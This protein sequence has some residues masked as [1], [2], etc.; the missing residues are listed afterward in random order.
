MLTRR[1]TALVEAFI[2]EPDDTLSDPPS[3]AEFEV[4]EEHVNQQLA[5]EQLLSE[6]AAARDVQMVTAADSTPRKTPR[7]CNIENELRLTPGQSN[8]L[9]VLMNEE[10]KKADILGK[11]NFYPKSKAQ[12]E[13]ALSHVIEAAKRELDFLGEKGVDEDR[14]NELLMARA[15]ICN[16]NEKHNEFM[17]KT[18]RVKARIS[19]VDPATASSAVSNIQQ[20]HIQQELASLDDD[21]PIAT[22]TRARSEARTERA[23]T[24]TPIRRRTR[25]STAI[26]ARL[27]DMDI[28]TAAQQ[29]AAEEE[30]VPAPADNDTEQQPPAI[31][32]QFNTGIFTLYPTA[33]LIRVIN[34]TTGAAIHAS[35][36][37]PASPTSIDDMSYQ[38]FIDKVTQAVGF[39]VRN[40]ISAVVP[41]ALGSAFVSNDVRITIT[42]E[43][44]WRA[45]LQLW[46]NARKRSCEFVVGGKGAVEG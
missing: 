15:H 3:D 24:P 45:A 7:V 14:L 28:G 10:M 29:E 19:I 37:L 17:V 33:F 12:H 41:K 1:K 16:S 36:L 26:A 38:A 43:Q 4:Q 25:K 13:E 46:Q 40:R 32:T 23:V 44:E 27:R 8:Q 30:A 35:Q 42:G 9:R 31:L 22:R 5:R 11:I 18:G 39:D 6:Q 20:E 2:N 21:A 34:S